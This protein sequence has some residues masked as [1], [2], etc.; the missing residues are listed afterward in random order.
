MSAAKF[1][2]F[3]GIVS[4]PLQLLAT[5]TPVTSAPVVMAMS[6]AEPGGPVMFHDPATDAGGVAYA[7]PLADPAEDAERAT[8]RAARASEPLPEWL[9]SG[10]LRHEAVIREAAAA[11]G[12]DP[13]A[14]AILTSIECPVG[15]PACRSW[16]GA[17]GLTQIMPGTAAYIQGATGYPCIT[18]ATD[19]LTS[20]KCGSWYFLE[21]LR[22]VGALW[23]EDSESAALGAAGVAYNWG[24]GN[25]G[26]VVRYAQQ[27]GYVC[28]GPMP[29]ES[30]S[31]CMQ[32][33]TAW[34]R[35][36]RQ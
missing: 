20:L 9:P 26:P 29:A 36:G 35:A 25:V 6:T 18:Q 7:A 3:V 2:I 19:P 14:L 10:V 31:W 23:Q 5:T 1:G 33:V 24:P 15:D 27:G 28:D 32:M 17:T 8:E 22:T 21:C 16:V 13:L 30:K 11:V 34:D 12:L 4:I